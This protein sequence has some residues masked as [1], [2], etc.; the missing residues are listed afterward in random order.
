MNE[1]PASAGEALL[2]DLQAASSGL[3]TPNTQP[4]SKQHWRRPARAA[5]TAAR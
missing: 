1:Q 3:L 2:V 4:A 5:P